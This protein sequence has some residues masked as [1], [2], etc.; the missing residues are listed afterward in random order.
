MPIKALPFS[1]PSGQYVSLASTISLTAD[2]TIECW[3]Y[4][5]GVAGVPFNNNTNGNKDV[6]LSDGTWSVNF[7]ADQFR[8]YDGSNDQRIASV[9]TASNAWVHHAIVRSGSSFLIYRN[10]TL[11]S[12]ATGTNNSSATASFANIGFG[13]GVLYAAYD[14]MEELR[15]WNVARSAGQISANYGYTIS[16]ATSGLVAYYNFAEA[17]A[18]TTATDIVAGTYTGTLQGTVTATR[19]AATAPVSDPPSATSDAMFFGMGV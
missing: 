17:D 13:G 11:D 10:G 14:G 4:R 15:V 8:L 5:T 1:N 9:T 2:F 3:L 7:Y 6:I 12:S 18:S 19:V 16:P